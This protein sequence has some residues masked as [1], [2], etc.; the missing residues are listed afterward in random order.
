MLVLETFLFYLLTCFFLKLQED[1]TLN[2]HS[3]VLLGSGV[4]A[5]VL[6]IKSYSWISD[7]IRS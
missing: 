1:F 7:K 2:I 6:K 4:I 5:Q 3:Y